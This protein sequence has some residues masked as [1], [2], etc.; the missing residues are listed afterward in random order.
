MTYTPVSG[1]IRKRFTALEVQFGFS[2][3]LLI[4]FL[5]FMFWTLDDSMQT[6]IDAHAPIEVVE[7]E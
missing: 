3:L 6:L 4:V 2:F 5:G 1:E 7:D